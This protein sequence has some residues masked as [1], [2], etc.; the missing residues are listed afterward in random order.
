MLSCTAQ[1]PSGRPSESPFRTAGFCN[2]RFWKI[3]DERA[4]ID[5]LEAYE[6]GVKYA[7]ITFGD[8]SSN[9]VMANKIRLLFPD[10]LTWGEVRI[11]LDRFYDAPENGPISLPDA[12]QIIVM[13][14]VG[15]QQSAIDKHISDV[16]QLANK[17][18]ARRGR[19]LAPAINQDL[20]HYPRH[21]ADHR[22]GSDPNSATFTGEKRAEVMAR[23]SGFRHITPESTRVATD[24]LERFA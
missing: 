15:L 21:L 23:F 13:K 3:L 12:L 10:G 11:A 8:I 9:Q 7:A 19:P 6:N 24:L 5:W 16:R 14:V 20:A 17:S 18:Q 1:A 22:P 4:K 2:G